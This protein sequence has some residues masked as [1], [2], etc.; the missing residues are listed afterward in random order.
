M[1]PPFMKV[2]ILLFD[3]FETLEVF[4]PAEILGILKEQYQLFFY[5]L[6]GGIVK[7]GHGVSVLTKKLN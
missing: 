3:D 7:N 4:G 1:K 6:S 5:S 2:A